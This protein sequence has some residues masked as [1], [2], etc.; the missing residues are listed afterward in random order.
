VAWTIFVNAFHFFCCAAML[1]SLTI[2]FFGD[3]KRVEALPQPQ[4]S[5]MA[6]STAVMNILMSGFYG[7]RLWRLSGNIILPGFVAVSTTI[8]TVVTLYCAIAALLYDG[9]TAEWFALHSWI[10]IFSVSCEI[11][12]SLVI[13]G[14]TTWFLR[15]SKSW[16]LRK[17]VRQIDRLIVWTVEIGLPPSVCRIIM[18]ILLV[19]YNHTDL[20]LGP[21]SLI[22]G[23]QANCLLAAINTTIVWRK[24]ESHVHIFPTNIG[25][26]LAGVEIHVA[27]SVRYN[28]QRNQFGSQ[29]TSHTSFA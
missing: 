19:H 4:F 14:G 29:K 8:S 22:A 2:S 11:A 6:T 21:Y 17:T 1:W 18:L 15:K 7:Y 20:F 23:V 26:E 27:E 13:T 24:K 3:V 28:D 25:T 5:A 10:I 12:G 9:S 16:A